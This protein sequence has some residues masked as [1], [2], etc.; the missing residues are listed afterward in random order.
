MNDNFQPGIDRVKNGKTALPKVTAVIAAYNEGD[1]IYHSLGYLINQGINVYLMDHCSTDNTVEQALPWLGK[2][3]VRIERFPDDAGYPEENREKFILLDVLKRKEEIVR[4]LDA[5][6]IVNQDVDEFRESPWQGVSLRQGIAVAD[7][8]GY[9]AIDFGVLKFMPTDNCFVPGGDVRKYL[10]YYKMV[11][12]GIHVKAW[13]NTGKKID[14]IGN[15]GHNV[16]FDGR[17]VFPLKFILR[18]YPVRSQEHG[19]KKVLQE[20]Q[21][22]YSEK[23]KKAGLHFQYDHIRDEK[24]NFIQKPEKLTL[25]EHD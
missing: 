13:K 17:K 20:R 8:A 23:A 10:R 16:Q 6:W 14:L 9:T 7:S 3:L 25:Y 18:H 21:N 5:D 15:A 11:K 4:D 22:R 19:I 2:G 1:I 12:K 24:Y